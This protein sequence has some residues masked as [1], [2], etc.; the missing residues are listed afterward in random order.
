MKHH[1]RSVD[2][3]LV[4]LP[5]V[6]K[7]FASGDGL[8]HLLEKSA[9]ARPGKS[10]EVV[11]LFARGFSQADDLFDFVL[12]GTPSSIGQAG[13]LRGYDEPRVDHKLM[14]KSLKC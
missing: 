10:L 14:G 1:L 11:S 12:L 6:A 4:G 9:F 13:K 7:V 8:T 5:V 2:E 3:S